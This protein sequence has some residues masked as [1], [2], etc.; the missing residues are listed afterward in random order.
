MH[1]MNDINNTATVIDI[2]ITYYTV[3]DHLICDLMHNSRMVYRINGVLTLE[4]FLSNAFPRIY[5]PNSRHILTVLT[6]RIPKNN[7]RLRYFTLY[8]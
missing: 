7:S 8:I 5:S 3:R 2:E 6:C 4:S 1:N